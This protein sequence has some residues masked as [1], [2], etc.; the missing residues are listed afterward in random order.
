MVFVEDQ[1]ARESHI[2]LPTMRAARM[3]VKFRMTHVLDA[4]AYRRRKV[5]ADP[6]AECAV[7]TFEL[8]RLGSLVDRRTLGRRLSNSHTA[9]RPSAFCID[10]QFLPGENLPTFKAL[11]TVR[12]IPDMATMQPSLVNYFRLE[13]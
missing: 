6:H 7:S 8:R 13:F 5:S 2:P 12:T 3:K 10:E 11:F 1:T 9:E 4:I